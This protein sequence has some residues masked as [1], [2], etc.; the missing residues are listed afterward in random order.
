MK[1]PVKNTITRKRESSQVNSKTVKNI[2]IAVAVIVAG[3]TGYKL[4][5]WNKTAAPVLPSAGNDNQPSGSN[6]AAQTPYVG[7]CNATPGEFPLAEGAGYSN[8]PNRKCEQEYIRIVQKFLNNR[9]TLLGYNRL[10]IDG[11]LGPKTMQAY[12][13]N[14]GDQYNEISYSAFRNIVKE[15]NA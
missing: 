10:F 4:L 12:K 2:I 14:F 9:S 15:L 13:W 7:S 11:Q 3:I 8:R 1:K 6:T 5:T